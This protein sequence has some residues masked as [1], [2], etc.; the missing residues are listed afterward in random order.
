MDRGQRRGDPQPPLSP[1]RR[2]PAGMTEGE[3]R[4][5]AEPLYPRE[6]AH[7]SATNTRCPAARPSPGSRTRSAVATARARTACSSCPGRV[8]RG[9]LLREPDGVAAPCPGDELFRQNGGSFCYPLWV[10]PRPAV[11]ISEQKLQA[12]LTK[13][14]I[15]TG[16]QNRTR[17]NFSRRAD[18]PPYGLVDDEVSR[19]SS[20]PAGQPLLV[21]GPGCRRRDQGQRTSCAASENYQACRQFLPDPVAADASRRGRNLYLARDTHSLSQ[22]RP[23]RYWHSGIDLLPPMFAPCLLG[24]PGTPRQHPVSPARRRYRRP[25]RMAALGTYRHLSAP[26]QREH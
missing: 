10:N 20:C 12:L 2:G 4:L 13:S 17:V 15:D 8:E 25:D 16:L 22:R 26:V 21:Q 6:P 24:C 7:G 14:R 3:R 19:G 23:R 5:A 18:Q 11:T 9:A 1:P